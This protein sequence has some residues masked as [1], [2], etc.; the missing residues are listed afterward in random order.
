MEK[1]YVYADFDFLDE[2]EL[3]GELSYERVRGN[4]HFAFEFS[5][6]WLKGH[7][8]IILS[9]DVMNVHALSILVREMACLAL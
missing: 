4:D 7:G 2:K 5:R 1:I 3:I 6:E 9:G 8:G